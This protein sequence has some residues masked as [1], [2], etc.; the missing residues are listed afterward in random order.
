MK[1]QR[2]FTLVELLVSIGVLAIVAVLGWRGLD[3]IVRTRV[4]LNDDLAQTRGLQLAFAQMQSDASH[5]A[6]AASIGG[7]PVLDAQSGRLTLVRTVFADNQPS[8]KQV[9]SYRLQNGVLV[10]R[11]STA[12]RELK[13]LDA[14]WSAA[15]SDSDTTP[16]VA[17]KSSVNELA[18]RVW[19]SDGMGWRLGT[20]ASA[21]T[22]SRTSTAPGMERY[23]GLEV[24]LQLQDRP[25]RMVKIFL[26]G[27]V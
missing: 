22:T 19:G 20:A 26:L 9:I 5:I 6:T 25:T 16:G 21:E 12:T 15:L 3:T 7:R 18:L 2:G 24:A 23:T 4:A 17:L 13:E 11:E 8:R 1:K 10:R 27:P 14:A